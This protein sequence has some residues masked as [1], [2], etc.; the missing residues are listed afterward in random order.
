MPRGRMTSGIQT[1]PSVKACQRLRCV[2]QL[3]RNGLLAV[4]AALQYNSQWEWDYRVL[5]F[6]QKT[7]LSKLIIFTSVK[8]YIE[9]KG[10]NRVLRTNHPSRAQ[11]PCDRSGFS[12][13]GNGYHTRN[14][15]PI[16]K[17]IVPRRLLV[18]LIVSVS[19]SA[20]LSWYFIFREF[21]GDLTF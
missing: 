10:K 13:W 9:E 11:G 19:V 18:G 2:E 8:F 17:Q 6:L 15:R 16:F 21:A 5:E 7:Q 14:F 1:S 3:F 4:L 20:M 12:G